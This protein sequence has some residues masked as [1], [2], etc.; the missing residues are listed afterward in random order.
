M[1]DQRMN[2]NKKTDDTSFFKIDPATVPEPSL[3]DAKFFGENPEVTMKTVTTKPTAPDDQPDKH[4]SDEVTSA[5]KPQKDEPWERPSPMAHDHHYKSWMA[6]IGLALIA[7]AFYRPVKVFVHKWIY[8][9]PVS[10]EERKS[11]EFIALAYYGVEES[12]APGSS[13]VSTAMFKEQMK[14]LKS[15]GYNP[16]TLKD[17]RDFYKLGTLLPNKAVLLTFEQA[18]R[19]TYN[20]VRDV[21]QSYKWPAVMGVNTLAVRSM[22]PE[23]LLWHYLREMHD[24][25]FWELAAESYLGFTEIETAPNDATATF[26]TSPKWIVSE[27]RYEMPAEFEKRIR[28]DHEA[29]IDEFMREV[30]D[31]PLAF[32]FPLGNYGQYDERA[33]VIRSVNLRQVEKNYDLGFSIGMLALNSNNSD[34]RRLN[35]LLVDPSW[36]PNAFISMVDS[37]WPRSWSEETKT[38]ITYTSGSWLADW[39]EVYSRGN[40][41]ILNAIPS[42]DEIDDLKTGISSGTTGAKAWLIGSD[43]FKD[44]HVSMLF[45]MRR[46]RFGIYLRAT[47]QGEYIFIIIDE[48]GNISARQKLS[49]V[50]ELILASDVMDTDVSVSHNI[51]VHLRDR[52]L[53]VQL[54]GKILF[55]G[56]IILRGEPRPGLIGASIWDSLTGVAAT[57]IISTRIRGR[58]D[59]V[60]SWSQETGRTGS[61][62]NKWLIEN[63]FRFAIISPPWI[64]IISTGTIAASEWDL[65]AVALVATSNGARVFP[66]IK[67]Q[68]VEALMR[69]AET[70]LSDKAKELGVDGIF[71]DASSCDETKMPALV[72]WLTRINESLR[73]GGMGLMLQ[74][75]TGFVKLSSSINIIKI[76]PGV[77]LVGDNLEAFKLPANRALPIVF[78]PPSDFNQTLNYYY[79]V[80]NIL[81][82]YNDIS[83]EAQN[84][85]LRQKGFEAFAAEAYDD[86]IREWALWAKKDPENAEPLS[87]IGDALL[88][89]DEKAKASEFYAACL[90]KNPGQVNLA[91]RQ[92]QLLF[93]MG[94]IDEATKLMDVYA[95][96]F[97]DNA[98]ICIAQARW[99]GKSRRRSDARDLMLGLVE[100]QPKNVE[101]RLVLQNYLDE[102]TNRYDNMHQL[103]DLAKSSESSLYGFAQEIISSELLTV[104]EATIF[105]PF[106]RNIAE[107]GPNARTQA[108]YDQLLPLTNSVVEDFTKS[109][110]SDAWI[111]WNGLHSPASGKYELHA[112]PSVSEAFLRLKKSELMRDGRLSVMIDES[113][114]SFWLYA[115]RSSRSMLRFGYDNDGYIR[116]QTWF[117]GQIRSAESQPWLRPPGIITLSLEIRGDGAMGF[118]NERALF[119][120][121]IKIPRE[122]CYGWWSI[123]PYSPNLGSAKASILTIEVSPLPS[124]LALL[125]MLDSEKIPAVLE[126]LRQNVRDISILAP[127]AIKQRPN[128]SM[129]TEPEIDLGPYK[130][131]CAF[132]RLRLIPIVEVPYFAMVK[133]SLL[134]EVINKNNLEGIIL[135]VTSMPPESWFE[136]LERALEQTAGSLMVV[137]SIEPLWPNIREKVP[138]DARDEY[139]RLKALD[140]VQIREIQLG[141]LIL[142][143][144]QDTWMIPPHPL[145]EWVAQSTEEKREGIATRLIIVP[146]TGS[147]EPDDLKAVQDEA[148]AIA[149]KNRKETEI[150]F[151]LPPAASTL[152]VDD[153]VTNILENALSLTNESEKI[154][155]T[156]PLTSVV[157]SVTNTDATKKPPRL[158]APPVSVITNPLPKPDKEEQSPLWKLLEEK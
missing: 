70:T 95:R 136:E 150:S 146:L 57:E 52:L 145:Q 58:R 118:E 128:G 155:V 28:D 116:M 148:E 35:R 102:P 98:E 133:P 12:P 77:I 105:F 9:A 67:V 85:E 48:R 107:S 32:F 92:S 49:D 50:D 14:L 129:S 39:G 84:E 114:G 142:P 130:M 13:S 83:G 156:L 21:L 101:A 40:T 36:S 80:A 41:L 149:L 4:N 100:S 45:N 86:A 59:A 3:E 111:P 16:I 132:H 19:G 56:R 158:P 125:P 87:L 93:D 73:E 7:I 11:T 110:L 81:T 122:T 69:I 18:K 10:T 137:Q 91:I 47:N 65:P 99:L 109:Y 152:R 44:G 31:K 20:Q 51:T 62:L 30:K 135:R 144:I 25:S 89:K 115:R 120:T 94:K 153:G 53:F 104:P 54:D 126:T 119:P 61:Y 17:V 37:F 75:P 60:V 131:F 108:I 34:P 134:T 76:I 143:P 2:E 88:K 24:L 90:E 117:D 123:A 154:P 140:K 127:V 97:P 8:K 71:I 121:R 27:N 78:V 43:T 66:A 33:R 106:I 138:L 112:S 46:G 124:G 26:F 68:D 141:N 15:G 55:G 157:S 96:T 74:L 103:L 38:A 42:L 151:A 29:V 147:V 6:F 72:S 64:E 79:Q 22:N 23:T 63:A 82:E 5:S 113:V 139:L 1:G